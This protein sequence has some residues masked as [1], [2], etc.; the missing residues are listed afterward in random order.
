MGGS[1]LTG[2][3][4]PPEET[5]THR[6]Q[7]DVPV[8]A[9]QN[10]SRT[11]SGSHSTGTGNENSKLR[12][13]IK[14][15][16]KTLKEE[17]ELA[18]VA[19]NNLEWY[20]EWHRIER[21]KEKEARALFWPTSRPYYND[22]A[23]PLKPRPKG[24][25]GDSSGKKQSKEP[26]PVP[27]EKGQPVKGK[28]S[29][30]PSAKPTQPAVKQTDSQM[31]SE[32]VKGAASA[33]NT[34]AS[35]AYPRKE[36]RP[37]VKRS[38]TK[39]SAIR[40]SPFAP[41]TSPD[42]SDDDTEHGGSSPFKKSLE[43]Y[44]TDFDNTPEILASSNAPPAPGELVLIGNDIAAVPNPSYWTSVLL[45]SLVPLASLILIYY[46]LTTNS[47]VDKSSILEILGALLLICLLLNG[48]LV[49][50]ISRNWH[51]T[52]RLIFFK[53]FFK[54]FLW[55][56][57]QAGNIV[58]GTGSSSDRTNST[59]AMF[60]RF[61]VFGMNTSL[62]RKIR[63]VFTH[64]G[65]WL[66][67]E[68]YAA[69]LI[70]L[71][72]Y[73]IEAFVQREWISFRNHL[74]YQLAKQH[75]YEWTD[76]IRDSKPSFSSWEPQVRLGIQSV[77]GSQTWNF[78]VSIIVTI[79]SFI[80]VL[81]SRISCNLVE[82][83]KELVQKCHGSYYPKY[84]GFFISG[85]V[86]EWLIVI[87]LKNAYSVV[88]KEAP[89]QLLATGKQFRASTASATRG[90]RMKR[91]MRLTPNGL[92][93][94]WDNTRKKKLSRSS[95]LSDMR[96]R[97]LFPP[98]SKF[99]FAIQPYRNTHWRFGE[100]G[101][102]STKTESAAASTT[103]KGA[104]TTI[105]S[106]RSGDANRSNA[107]INKL[108][109]LQRL[110]IYTIIIGYWGWLLLTGWY[111]LALVACAKCKTWIETGL[112]RWHA[113]L[114][115]EANDRGSK[116]AAADRPPA[117][118]AEEEQVEMPYIPPTPPAWYWRL[119]LRL[120]IGILYLFFFAS[121][122]LGY[123]ASVSYSI[124]NRTLFPVLSILSNTWNC[125]CE[126]IASLFRPILQFTSTILG[127]INKYLVLIQ[128]ITN[129]QFVLIFMAWNTGL[130]DDWIPRL[131]DDSVRLILLTFTIVVNLFLTILVRG[132]LREGV[133]VE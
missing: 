18:A 99:Y 133:V 80:T 106:P 40:W 15:L 1:S 116:G 32:Q 94:A 39:L 100:A 59:D 75:A 11:S 68:A 16:K 45:V 20:E 51:P 44:D 5:D 108:S 13:E 22:L 50:R 78:L 26:N 31:N 84:L 35:S 112:D 104:E 91:L 88:E 73:D 12:K 53:G 9:S 49:E 3:P 62:R 117:A 83:I 33:Q 61:S 46:T 121:V 8:K 19:Y 47:I 71:L 127:F 89:S 10:G 58:Y 4:D 25:G 72:F 30:G 42:S 96:F 132:Y 81:V 131:G 122:A 56:I 55:P 120:A 76:R 98:I 52:W 119:R 64:H 54:R 95:N 7:K 103:P 126:D 92:T 41:T 109:L 74:A 60:R 129:F 113:T 118:A 107:V 24:Q 14:G 38:R 125:I 123:F 48:D 130:L 57:Y 128:I 67:L 87:L 115:G 101:R 93:W 90:Q 43:V 70:A 2:S 97:D 110:N 66:Y 85:L 63:V 114:F 6:T 34:A 37:F 69:L 17:R 102:A 86:I 77:L 23:P 105:E 79:Q 36:V 82:S 28:F 21:E 27:K 65:H 111:M 29:A 124:L